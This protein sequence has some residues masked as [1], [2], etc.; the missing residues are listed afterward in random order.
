MV[1]SET[2]QILNRERNV[3]G[4]MPHPG[5]ASDPLM[6]RPTASRFPVLVSALGASP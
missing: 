5:K 1:R 6:D 4:K 3:M 2:S